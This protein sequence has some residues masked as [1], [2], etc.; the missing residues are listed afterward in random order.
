MAYLVNDL[1]RLFTSDGSADREQIVFGNIGSFS[2][3]A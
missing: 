2:V 1:S 3:D